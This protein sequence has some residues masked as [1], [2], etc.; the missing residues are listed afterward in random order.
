[1]NFRDFLAHGAAPPSAAGRFACVPEPR[2]QARAA[3]Y[4]LV[5]FHFH[6]PS[7]EKINGK[8]LCSRTCHKLNAAGK[9]SM[10]VS[11]PDLLPAA[12]GYFRYV[13]SLT[14]PSCSDDVRWQVLKQPQS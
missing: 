3:P 14:T 2:P 6:A 7:E 12:G 4:R 13:G 10:P 9:H 11:M 1:M 8:A 5:Q